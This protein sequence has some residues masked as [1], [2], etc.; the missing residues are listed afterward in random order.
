MFLETS[1]VEK[2][3]RIIKVPDWGSFIGTSIGFNGTARKCFSEGS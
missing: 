2:E 1:K 3:E